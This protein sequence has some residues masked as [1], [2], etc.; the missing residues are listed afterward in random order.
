ML[1]FCCDIST[2]KASNFKEWIHF[3]NQLIIHCIYLEIIMENFLIIQLKSLQHVL[4]L[5]ANVTLQKSSRWFQFLV[6]FIFA[7]IGFSILSIIICYHFTIKHNINHTT[8]TIMGMVIFW[9]SFLASFGLLYLLF[10]QNPS[11]RPENLKKSSQ[12]KT[13]EIE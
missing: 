6:C 1:A 11:S 12:K 8:L 13:R 5:A 10:H 9:M 2:E 4:D 7:G 3:F